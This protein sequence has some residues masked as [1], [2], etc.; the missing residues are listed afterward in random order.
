MSPLFMLEMT[1]GGNSMGRPIYFYNE[2]SS[3]LYMDAFLSLLEYGKEV[4]PRGKLTKELHPVTVGFANP[5]SRATFVKGRT[6]NPFFQLAEP[7]WITEGRSDVEWLKPY[8]ASIAQ[9]SD[10]GVYFNAPYGERLRHWGKNDAR[11]FI[12]NPID[13]L[14][15]CYLK[16]KED[17]QTRQ[18][19][20]FIGNPQFDN[21]EYTH[22]GGKDIACN[23]NIK[24]KIR[25]GKL[26]ITVDNRSNDLHWGLFGANLSQFGFI[27]EVMASWLDV[28]VGEYF[29]QADSLH[30]YMND[31]GAKC[32][33]PILKA[34]GIG[35]VHEDKE[36]PDVQ[37][38]LFE[39]EP[40][41]SS[42]YEEFQSTMRFF[43]ERIDPVMNH[44]PTW[45]VSEEWMLVLDNILV[46]PDDY[47]RMAFTAMFVKQAHNRGIMDA[48]LDG[49]EAMADSSWK[50]SCMRWLYPKYKDNEEFHELYS[51]TSQDIKDYIE[52]K[53][54]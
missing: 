20:A 29:Q 17:P 19:V 27:Q 8:N 33:D 37:E 12:F 4:G 2:N 50:V 3:Q 23:L 11:G 5:L 52:R 35:N 28:P 40:R 54:E 13:Q 18:A 15:D 38:F 10:D 44:E 46:C 14:Y 25:E 47:L 42:T 53:G 9:F 49:M 21:S 41:I 31:Y 26:D 7:I 24:F 22:S 51:S 43:F 16:L 39:H 45:E 30:I 48:V 36:S 6:M 1:L 34:Y 32:N